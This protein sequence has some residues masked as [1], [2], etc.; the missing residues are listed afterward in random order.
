MQISIYHIKGKLLV[1]AFLLLFS[2]QGNAQATIVPA[3]GSVH[4]QNGSLSY[5]V[6]QVDFAQAKSTSSSINAGIQQP[7]SMDTTTEQKKNINA[8]IELSVYPNPTKNSFQVSLKN[9]IQWHDFSITD[10]E[11][12]ILRQGTVKNGSIVSL[13]DQPIGAY[14]FKLFLNNSEFITL[15][16]IKE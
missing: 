10:I 3:G 2:I 7:N 11:G 13:E 1:S 12:R 6:G 5:S 9:D 14:L 4:N 16:I 15:K 8:Q